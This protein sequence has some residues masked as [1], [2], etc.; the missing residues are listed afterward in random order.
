MKRRRQ[1]IDH[2]LDWRSP[3]MPV[4]RDYTMGNG[5]VR[6]VVDPDYERGYR[7]FLMN[8]TKHPHYKLDPT[9]DMKR[10]RKPK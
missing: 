3:Q 6:N 2:R 4:L 5:E 1:P 7:E 10:E 8:T 9:Y